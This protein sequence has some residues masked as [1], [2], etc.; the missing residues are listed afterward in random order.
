MYRVTSTCRVARCTAS[1]RRVA[2]RDVPRHFDV[3]RCAMYRV[4]STC[5]VARCT[6]SLR[7]VALRDVPRHFDVSRYVMYRVTSTCR[8]CGAV[9]ATCQQKAHAKITCVTLARFRWLISRVLSSTGIASYRAAVIP[10]GPTLPSVLKQ[11][12]QG[13]GRAVLRRPSTWPCSGRGLHCRRRYRLRGG[14]LLHPFTL[15][16]RVNW[17]GGLL[18]VA[19][20]SRFPSPGV[21]RHPAL[22]S[23]DFPPILS[24]RRSPELPERGRA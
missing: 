14:L 16:R 11:P 12:T 15:T 20:S 19:L 8:V 1:L 24:D 2:L 18:S 13:L 10:L 17:S 6:A 9:V 23:P 7:R 22:R 3:S 21:T 5:R 4:T